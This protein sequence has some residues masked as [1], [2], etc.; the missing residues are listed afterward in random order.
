MP[1]FK[2]YG[3]YS[4]KAVDM[5]LGSAY[6]TRPNG[7]KVEITCV[8]DDVNGSDYKLADKVCVG[9]VVKYV[10]VCKKDEVFDDFDDFDYDYKDDYE[11]EKYLHVLDT[12]IEM[13]DRLDNEFILRSMFR[14]QLSIFP[15]K[16]KLV[17]K[18]N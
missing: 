5:G 17:N 6:Y 7:S 3:F 1:S 16:N 13:A 14:G 8:C 10:G 9:E 12:K 4:Q 11:D 15:T 18:P 2:Q